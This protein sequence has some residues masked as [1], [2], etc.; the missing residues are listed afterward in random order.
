MHTGKLPPSLLTQPIAWS[1][2]TSATSWQISPFLRWAPGLGLE[3]KQLALQGWGEALQAGARDE[4]QVVTRTG[5]CAFKPPFHLG[6]PTPALEGRVAPERPLILHSP[7]SPL[8]FPSPPPLI[9]S[10]PRP[11]GRLPAFRHLA[12]CRTPGASERQAS[13]GD[14]AA[15]GAAM[16]PAGGARALCCQPA[17]SPPP[18]RQLPASRAGCCRPA[19]LHM[20]RRPAP[21][22]PTPVQSSG[23]RAP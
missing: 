16:E 4:T 21:L 6:K 7:L 9:P 3:S 17:R 15:R 19:N 18:A 13:H 8:P 5:S 11:S 1:K 22:S 20:P 2:W 10:P 12:A 14:G 23:T